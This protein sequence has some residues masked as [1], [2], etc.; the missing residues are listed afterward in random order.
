MD[1][2]YFWTLSNSIFLLSLHFPI[3]ISTSSFFFLAPLLSLHLSIA[4]STFYHLSFKTPTFSSLFFSNVYFLFT[5]LLKSLL[6]SPFY[7]TSILSLQFSVGIFILPDFCWN[8]YFLFTFLLKSLLSSHFS[9]EIL[10]L[11]LQSFQMKS[12]LSLRFPIGISTSGN[13]GPTIT[14]HVAI[15]N[16]VPQ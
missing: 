2:L 12:I 8:L 11:S 9:F 1:W 13:L 16:C 7:S 3:D 4:I 5:F 6:F 15:C 10:L 14:R